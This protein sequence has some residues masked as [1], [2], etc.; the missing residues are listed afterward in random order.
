MRVCKAEF[1]VASLDFFSSF[2][3]GEKR[4]IRY[5]IS[6]KRRPHHERWL[7]NPKN[8]EYIQKCGVKSC[9]TQNGAKQ[10]W[11]VDRFYQIIIN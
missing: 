9:D 7:H 8:L 5:E 6:N 2:A 1:Y 4:P 10:I 11:V 3:D